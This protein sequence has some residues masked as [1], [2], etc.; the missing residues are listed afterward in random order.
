MNMS[1]NQKQKQ[2]IKTHK[3][4]SIWHADQTKAESGCGLLALAWMNT[5]IKITNVV[6]AG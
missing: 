1:V 4:M 6:S 5:R 3:G 2:D